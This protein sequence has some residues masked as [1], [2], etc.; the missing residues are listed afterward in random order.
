MSAILVHKDRT[1]GVGENYGGI[2]MRWMSLRI[3]LSCSAIFAM[4]FP[5]LQF[6]IH[7]ETKGLILCC[8]VVI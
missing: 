3:G 8:L 4:S 1:E 6:K 7:C 2:E 5:K